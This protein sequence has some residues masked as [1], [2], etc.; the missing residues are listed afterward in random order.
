MDKPEFAA[1]LISLGYKTEICADGVVVVVDKPGEVSRT[2]DKLFR[3][4]ARKCGYDG[5]GGVRARRKEE[6]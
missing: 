5:S 1:H 4:E 2:Y 6:P 3:K